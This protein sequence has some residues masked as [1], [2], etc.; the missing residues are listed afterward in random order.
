M[1]HI[2]PMNPINPISPI[3]RQ[4]AKPSGRPQPSVGSR[5]YGLAFVL[6]DSWRSGSKVGRMSGSGSSGFWG[7]WWMVVIPASTSKA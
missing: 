7:G 2:N 3:I 4:P 5:G 1:N 6:N